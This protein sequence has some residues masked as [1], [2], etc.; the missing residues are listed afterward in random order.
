MKRLFTTTLFLFFSTIV[1]QA[2]VRPYI[3]AG[4]GVSR[5]IGGGVSQN[6]S[7]DQPLELAG[8]EPVAGQL[9]GRL[10]RVVPNASAGLVVPVG[11]HF[12]IQTEI[13]LEQ[14]GSV[15]TIGSIDDH[16]VSVCAC[17]P[18]ATGAVS[19][20]LTYLMLPILVGFRTGQATVAVGPYVGYKLDEQLSGSFQEVYSSNRTEIRSTRT[21]YQDV[22]V[23]FNAEL[24]YAL[25]T[26]FGIDLRYSQ[27][28]RSIG[29]PYKRTYYTL[30]NYPVY[31]QTAQ[32]SVRYNLG[33]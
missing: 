15:M 30:Y 32:L 28:S 3:R 24:S 17:Y 18:K 21:N 33:R 8:E 22:D 29:R 6:G 1:T 4:V 11:R 13:G 2:Q 27:S 7:I 26:S 31:N 16:L 10:T 19:S 14:K 12:T 5:A 20:R 23:G 25:T 9:G